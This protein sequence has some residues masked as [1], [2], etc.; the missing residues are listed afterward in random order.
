V[1]R[2]LDDRVRELANR[3]IAAS[4]ADVDVEPILKELLALV[5]EKL[6]RLRRIAMSH[7]LEG[8]PV[9]ER[10]SNEPDYNGLNRQVAK[11]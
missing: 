7:L 10:R 9:K 8:G 1:N 5:H 2:R 6:E 11:P 3:A 4:Q